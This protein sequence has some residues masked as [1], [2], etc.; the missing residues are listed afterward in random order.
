[1]TFKQ[2][3][4]FHLKTTA[5]IGFL[6]GFLF[7]VYDA[8]VVLFRYT[9]VLLDSFS[10][11]TRIIILPTFFWILIWIVLML[12]FGLSL[13]F[14]MRLNG[15]HLTKKQTISLHVGTFIFLLILAIIVFSSNIAFNMSWGKRVYDVTL[16]S[17]ISIFSGFGAFFLAD[18]ILKK[19]SLKKIFVSGAVGVF[20]LLILGILLY[21]LSFF[22]LFQ[23][24][25]TN[26][27]RSENNLSR[28]ENTQT[29]K[30]DNK[31]QPNI[32]WIVMDTVRADHLSSYGYQ[33][34]TTPNI[35]AV[36]REGTRYENAISAAPWTIPSHASMFTG[37]YP[38]KHGTNGDWFWMDEKWTTVAEA[39]GNTGYYTA[40]IINNGLLSKKNFDQGFENFDIIYAFNQQQIE[41]L[42]AKTIQKIQDIFQI[43]SNILGNITIKRLVRPVIDSGADLTNRQAKR[44]MLD[45]SQKN[46][47]L[48]LFLNYAEAHGPHGNTPDATIYL[49]AD[50]DPTTALI[51]N[52]ITKQDFKFE[53]IGDD[54][55]TKK[56]EKKTQ[57]LKDLYDGDLHYL[58]SKIGELIKFM[59][60][61]HLLDQT[62]VIITSD[63][64]EN[65]GEHRKIDH[66]YDIHRTL[67][68]VPLI[69]R[70]PK[71]FEPGKTKSEIV[72]LVDIFPT[73]LDIVGNTEDLSKQ[74]QGYSLLSSK[75]HEIAIS[76]STLKMTFH[77][78]DEIRS[79]NKN[80]DPRLLGGDWYSIQS[81]EYEYIFHALNQYLYNLTADPQEKHNLIDEEPEK[82]AEMRQMLIAWLGSFKHYWDP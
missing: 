50:T 56:L 44:Y 21:T 55:E 66:L 51:H 60:S 22:S 1:M 18:F 27:S 20:F 26:L 65:F 82:A 63:H 29:K 76:E 36:A 74:I 23:R 32:L 80:L 39:L 49:D 71:L 77:N 6:G 16:F 15:A 48:F 81:T 5:A 41:S 72:Q 79:E 58:D 4:L 67:T 40:A 61:S 10:D 8:C 28:S 64:G 62:I 57:I 68:H 2:S 11:A 75:R 53:Y 19:Y 35:D 54:I 30:I 33:R 7:G 73:I 9:Y 70:Y 25:E 69:I 34:E 13:F 78:I 59:R 24:Q 52:Q 46:Q 17:G 31:S 3:F 45:S 37:M 43:H 42:L 12:F 38:S 47:P 14:L